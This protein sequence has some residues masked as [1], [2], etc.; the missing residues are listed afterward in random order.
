[1]LVQT[2]HHAFVVDRGEHETETI[3]RAVVQRVRQQLDLNPSLI[4]S[5]DQLIDRTRKEIATS[6]L[7]KK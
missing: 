1:M 7:N 5:L 2:N 3:F 6:E 4:H